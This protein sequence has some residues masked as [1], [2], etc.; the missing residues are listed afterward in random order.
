MMRLRSAW[1]TWAVDSRPNDCVESSDS[2]DTPAD[3]FERIEM[4]G[5]WFIGSMPRQR[6][7]L[8]TDVNARKVPGLARSSQQGVA[9]RLVVD[10]NVNG[11][12][13]TQCV[14]RNRYVRWLQRG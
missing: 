10:G 7:R 13:F 12:N 14:L 8:R 11:S 2:R 6:Q 9:A 5:R 1:M 4:L 3:R